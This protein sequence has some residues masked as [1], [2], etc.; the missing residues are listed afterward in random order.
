MS[1]ECR[2]HFNTS[3]RSFTT[4]GIFLSEDYVD[5]YGALPLQSAVCKLEHA[6]SSS[7]LVETPVPI[8]PRA[9]FGEESVSATEPTEGLV[10][11]DPPEEPPE[12]PVVVPNTSV[13]THHCEDKDAMAACAILDIAFSMR[14]K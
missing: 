7:F 4:D 10:D 3:F 12:P 6:T 11:P 1:V 14:K 13:S 5:L 8:L 2:I 9:I